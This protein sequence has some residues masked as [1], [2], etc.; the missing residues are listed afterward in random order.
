MAEKEKLGEQACV[1]CGEPSYLQYDKNGKLFTL[2][3]GRHPQ[4]A[5]CGVRI[6]WGQKNSARLKAQHA[7]KGA[8]HGNGA[9]GKKAANDNAP[10]AANDNPGAGGG[11]V[12]GKSGDDWGAGW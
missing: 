5:G 10:E 2:C 7:Q 11:S 3:D 12:G 4:A 1:A 9:T 8:K 6:W